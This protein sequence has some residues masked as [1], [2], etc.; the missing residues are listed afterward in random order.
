MFL[1]FAVL[2]LFV[3]QELHGAESQVGMIMGAFAVSAVL[4]RPLSGRLVDTWSRKSC[5]TLGALIYVIFSAALHSG[6]LST[7]HDAP[8]DS[9]MA[10][11]LPFIRLPAVCLLLTSRLQPGV[12]KRWVITAW[13]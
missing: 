9:F 11:A 10:S 5:L 12:A 7:C 8:D 13:Q 2:P 1:L 6:H 3:V 4:S